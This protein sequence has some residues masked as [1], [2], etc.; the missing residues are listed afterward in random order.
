MGVN[1]Q[2]DAMVIMESIQQ[3]NNRIKKNVIEPIE[4]KLIDSYDEHPFRIP[5]EIFQ[6][7]TNEASMF[8]LTRVE[9]EVFQQNIPT[10]QDV[11]V[12]TV[13]I[14]D[15]SLLVPKICARFAHTNEKFITCSQL[16]D[17]L[18]PL[19]T[20]QK[21][22]LSYLQLFPKDHKA[23]YESELKKWIPFVLFA[24]AFILCGRFEV[25]LKMSL[26]SLS[27]EIFDLCTQVLHT[28]NRKEMMIWSFYFFVPLC[29]Q[30]ISKEEWIEV[31][32]VPKF[33]L[34][35]AIEQVPFPYLSGDQL[36]RVLALVFPLIDDLQDATQLVGVK[37]LLHIIK[38]VTPTDLRWY[39]DVLFE[40]LRVAITTRKPMT[41]DYLLECLGLS[42]EMVSLRN[43]LEFYDK[44]FPRLL[45]D[46]SLATEIPIRIIYT[47]RLIPLIKRMGA[48][49][50]LHLIRYLQPLLKVL[51]S[52]F[53]CLNPNLIEETLITLRQVIRR[54]WLRIPSHTEQIF[55]GIMR[56]VLFCDF[57]DNPQIECTESKKE[58]I[59][60]LCEDLLFLLHELTKEKNIIPAMMNKLTTK[61]TIYQKF[62][63]RFEIKLQ[64]QLGTTGTG[65][66]IGK[67]NS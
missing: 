42:L 1:K 32:S 19:F 52:S 10:L 40:V 20:F 39:S 54:A 29:S 51:L 45:T 67:D 44:F 2:Q 48:P 57:V 43:E 4:K 63:V 11:E 66:N 31:K 61:C 55:I 26:A 17:Y 41:L 47:R 49:N 37:M 12:I 50:S 56:A 22:F 8:E 23:L 36:G 13:L 65:S 5:L 7:L 64:Q 38:N 21:N 53:Q 59:R 24:N 3:M 18:S 30:G 28:K 15:L 34:L 25:C 46:M 16:D 58:E 60:T 14:K 62:S 9:K 35:W 27:N 33:V 6:T